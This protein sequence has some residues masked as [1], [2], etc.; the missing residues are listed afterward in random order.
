MAGLNQLKRIGIFGG[1]FDPP[2]LGHLILASEAAFQLE[3]GTVFW[4]LTKNPPHKLR[5]QITPVEIRIE[6]LKA[7]ISQDRRFMLSRVEIDRPPPHFAVDTLHMLQASQPNANLVYLMGGDSLHELP[8]WHDP[9]GIIKICASI[10]V[11]RRSGGTADLEALEAKL[12]G[13]RNKIRWVETPIID[14]SSSLVRQKVCQGTPYCY[15]V[16]PAVAELVEKYHLYLD[17]NE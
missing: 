8:T 11:M 7:A 9:N 16:P 13:I 10:G 1:T 17:S 14:I 5:R 6:L 12:P 15:Y 3:L 4:V 2:H